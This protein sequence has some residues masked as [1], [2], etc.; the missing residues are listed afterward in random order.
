LSRESDAPECGKTLSARLTTDLITGRQMA[1]DK[2]FSA[3]GAVKPISREL[4]CGM[5]L[6]RAGTVAAP[7]AGLELGP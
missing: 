2:K 1:G 5:L 6:F 7:F 4:K 3:C